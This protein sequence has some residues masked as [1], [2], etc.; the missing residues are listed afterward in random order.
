M[1]ISRV[2]FLVFHKYELSGGGEPG[3]EANHSLVSVIALHA[4]E[5]GREGLEGIYFA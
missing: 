3:Y 4:R 5:A 1:Y 2:Y